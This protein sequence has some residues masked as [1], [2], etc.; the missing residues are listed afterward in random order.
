[1]MSGEITKKINRHLASSQKIQGIGIV[2]EANYH[3]TYKPSKDTKN[4]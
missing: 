1:M 4:K 3:Q 2:P